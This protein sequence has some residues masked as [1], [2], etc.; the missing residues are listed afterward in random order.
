[1]YVCTCCE[2]KG[3]IALYVPLYNKLGIVTMVNIKQLV[4]T[5]KAPI[6]V[7]ETKSLNDQY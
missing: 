4:W 6:V 7:K 3:Y 1:M 5:T 2:W